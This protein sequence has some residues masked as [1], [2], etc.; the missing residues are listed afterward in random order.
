[1]YRC[2][3]LLGYGVLRMVNERQRPSLALL[4]RP[5]IDRIGSLLASIRSSLN[6]AMRDHQ[7]HDVA[8]FQFCY[9]R[10]PFP[11]HFDVY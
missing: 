11:L 3:S 5:E 10:Y 2:S 4:W 6:A 8:C 7:S 1:M 9:H